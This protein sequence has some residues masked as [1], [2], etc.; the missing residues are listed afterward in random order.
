MRH[1]RHLFLKLVAQLPRPQSSLLIQL[2]TGHA[3]L[4]QHLFRIGKVPSPL[5]PACKQ[6]DETVPHFVL[7]CDAHEPHR[8][9]LRR[10]GPQRGYSLAYLL[11]DADCIPHLFR[12][13]AATERL[14]TTFT[15]LS[16]E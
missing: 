7:H 9:L 12:Y 3:P 8:Y 1:P 13:I 11:S 14:R 5:C 4:N 15:D 6:H 10:A 2:R 16:S